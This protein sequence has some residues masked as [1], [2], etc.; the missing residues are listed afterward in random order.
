MLIGVSIKVIVVAF[1]RLKDCR[2]KNRL[3]LMHAVSWQYTMTHYLSYMR[4]ICTYYVCSIV[5][6]I[7]ANYDH[8]SKSTFKANNT[9]LR[10][11]IIL[12]TTVTYWLALVYLSC[13][14]F[15]IESIWV[16]YILNES[17]LT[18][19]DTLC[20]RLWSWSIMVITRYDASGFFLFGCT[21]C[22]A[23]LEP[24]SLLIEGL[25]SRRWKILIKIIWILI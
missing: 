14:L 22:K 10:K 2:N 19:L 15:V 11:H 3:T 25:K 13:Q 8:T 23:A 21:D 24:T 7:R 16:I 17:F 6:T 1:E 9:N 4:T 12:R 5:T 18:H 20:N